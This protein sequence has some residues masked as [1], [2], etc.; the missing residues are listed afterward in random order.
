MSRITLNQ[1]FSVLEGNL[2][3]E[4]VLISWQNGEVNL[5][6]ESWLSRLASRWVQLHR[7]INKKDRL[8]AMNHLTLFGKYGA[9][10]HDV[11]HLLWL[12]VQTDTNKKPVIYQTITADL[13]GLV[14]SEESGSN[15]KTADGSSERPWKQSD[16]SLN[17]SP[18]K[19]CF[20]QTY[21]NDK[22]HEM[23]ASFARIIAASCSS[24][25]A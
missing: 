18:L 19:H 21:W 20:L 7:S 5:G 10:L 8:K 15:T 23:V 24:F 22:K 4:S 3:K 16:V 12:M 6:S 11:G 2:I 9:E 13:N 17:D 1:S 14:R 25:G